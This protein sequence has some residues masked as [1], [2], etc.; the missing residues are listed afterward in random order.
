MATTKANTRV[1]VIKIESYEGDD[2]FVRCG[3]E[4]QDHLFAI[5][6][7]DPD[8]NAEIVDSSYRTMQEALEAW[9]EA[10]PMKGTANRR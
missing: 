3:D 8:G 9:P 2:T 10:G 6:S 4:Q 5:V 1:V 7:I